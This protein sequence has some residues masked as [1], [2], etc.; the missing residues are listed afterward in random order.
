MICMIEKRVKDLTRHVTKEDI[1]MKNKHMKRFSMLSVIREVQIKTT[2]RCH[3]APIRMAKI[4]K[5]VTPN[6]G[7]DV[8]QQKLSW[9]VGMQDGTVTLEDSLLV[10]YETKY[11]LNTQSNNCTHW[12]LSKGF[13]KLYP[14]KHLHAGVYSRFIKCQNLEAS[15]ISFSW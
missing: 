14:H 8:E 13:K 3:Y 7:Q 9:L 4:W 1:Q 6:A 15:M 12:Y 11:T 10:Y 2:M 5:T